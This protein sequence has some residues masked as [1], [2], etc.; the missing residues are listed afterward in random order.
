RDTLFA[1]IARD[2]VFV[3]TGALE[4]AQEMRVTAGRVG[5]VADEAGDVVVDDERKVGLRGFE[6]GVETCVKRGVGFEGY[7][8]GGVE[9]RGLDDGRETVALLKRSDLERVDGVEEM[10]KLVVE[11]RVALEVEAAGQHQVYGGVEVGARSL[12]VTGAVVVHT[13]AVGLLHA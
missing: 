11:L 4:R 1:E 12:E 8:V 13:A 3:L 10:L 9:R 5:E 7:L 2:H 6:L